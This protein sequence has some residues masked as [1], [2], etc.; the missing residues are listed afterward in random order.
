MVRKIFLGEESALPEVMEFVLR[1]VV[2]Q[3]PDGDLAH[4]TYVRQLEWIS[5]HDVRFHPSEEVSEDRSL[6]ERELALPVA[7]LIPRHRAAVAAAAVADAIDEPGHDE[8]ELNR[9][10]PP[11]HPSS[12]RPLQHQVGRLDVDLQG[13]KEMESLQSGLGFEGTI[14]RQKCRGINTFE[15]DDLKLEEQLKLLNKPPV[16]TFLRATIRHDRPEIRKY[17]TSAY[18]SVYN[19]TVARDQYSAHN[20]WIST[21]PLDRFSMIAAGWQVHPVVGGDYLPRLFTYWTGNSWRDGCYNTFCQGF[22]QVDRIITPNYP[23]KP[24][25]THGGPIYELKVEVSQDLYTGSWWLRI[26]DRNVGYWPKELFVNLQDG[27]LTTAWGGV[28]QESAEGYCPPMGNG[29]LP[30]VDYRKAAYFRDVRW[31]NARGESFPPR[32]AMPVEVDAA[33]SCYGLL[34]LKLRPDPWGYY[35]SYGGPGGYCRGYSFLRV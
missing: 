8:L 12:P 27:T 5:G 6:V 23:I 18:I 16:A 7:D 31:M 13:S 10:E 14:Q 32:E 2:G 19:L 28:A 24:V 20:I 26:C 3:K 34:D 22:V 15:D 30:D 1:W 33:P 17:G 4:A 29:V 11:E 25:S 35:F 9:K 21:G